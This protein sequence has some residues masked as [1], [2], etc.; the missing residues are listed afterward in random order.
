MRIDTNRS[1]IATAGRFLARLAHDRAG[2][3][4]MIVAFSLLPI[5]A[6]IGGGIDLGRGYLSQSRLQQ[7]CDAG[8]LAARKKLGKDLIVNATPTAAVKAEGDKFFNA[9][10]K[11]GAYGTGTRNFT[12]TIGSNYNITGNADVRVPTTLMFL[13]GYTE[14][15]VAVTCTARLNFSNTDVMMVLDVTG[16]MNE[17]NPTDTKPRIEVLKDVVKTFHGNMEAEKTP[18]T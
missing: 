16:S 1:L 18:G 7:A 3:T 6:M 15:N 11:D 4:I 12:M 14:L 8:V 17:I 13:F 5:L 9:N 2:N 10:F